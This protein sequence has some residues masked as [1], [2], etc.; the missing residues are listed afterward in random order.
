MDQLNSVDNVASKYWFR[1]LNVQPREGGSRSISTESLLFVSS[2]NISGGNFLTNS[3]SG[4]LI[5]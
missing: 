4:D 1:M 2:F 5:R 3:D